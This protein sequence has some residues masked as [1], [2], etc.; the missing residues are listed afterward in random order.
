MMARKVKT[1][2]ATKVIG[3]TVTNDDWRWREYKARLGVNDA[4]PR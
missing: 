1:V 3:L 2:K 4:R